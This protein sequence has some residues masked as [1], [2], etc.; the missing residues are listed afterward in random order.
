MGR[1]RNMDGKFVPVGLKIRFEVINRLYQSPSASVKIPSARELAA[2]F[3]LS[4]STVTLELQKLIKEGYLIGKRGSG[5][6]TNP[7]RVH[8]LPASGSRRVV[9]ILIDDGKHLFYDSVSWA[10]QSWCGMALPPDFAHPRFLTLLA[11]SGENLYEELT[12]QALAGLIW[13]NSRQE[14]HETMRKLLQNGFPVVAVKCDAPGIPAIDYSY[15]QSGMQ[16]AACMAKEKR[17]L[18]YYAPLNDEWPQ[19]RAAGMEHYIRQHPESGMKLKLF[20]SI[21]TCTEELEREFSVGNV[22]DAVYC[23]GEYV[24]V[25]LEL[26]KKY[27][28]DIV[29]RCRL[30]AEEQHLLHCGTFHGYVLRYP[31]REIGET[32]VEM[33][34]HLF[35]NPQT[36]LAVRQVR[37]ELLFRSASE[38]L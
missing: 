14:H 16:I 27:H 5:T 10:V 29:D 18:I 37:Q 38:L 28:L 30:F 36:P 33:L 2:Q 26:A 25:M 34:K 13:I 6:Y 9:G 24:F 35:K 31:F 21:H 3:H 23:N 17:R 32:A 20:P 4:P 22:P 11:E 15:F 12:G 7:S 1:H 19:Q 8:F